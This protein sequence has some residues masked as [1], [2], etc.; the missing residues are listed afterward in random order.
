MDFSKIFL[1]D[2]CPTKVGGQAVL[3]GIM[4]K[5]EKRSAT[6]LRLPDGSI[7]L[8]TEE[9]KKPSKG[10]RIPFIRG[11]IV[12]F[13]SLVQGMKVLMYSADVLEACEAER[14]QEEGEEEDKLTAWLEEKFGEKGA[15]NIMI[16]ASVIFSLIFTVVVFII[17]P[18]WVVGLCRAFMENE[19]LLNLIEGVLRI[20]MFLLYVVIIARMPEIHRVFQYHGAEHQCI[21]CFENGEDLTP[22]NC[23][24]YY[25]LHPR[26]GTSFL[27]F[28]LVISLIL[29]SLC[30]WPDLFWRITSRLLLL[31]VISGISYELLRLAGRSDGM[32]VKVMSIPGL[33]MQ[34][35]TT[36]KPDRKELE[37]AIAAMKAAMDEKRPLGEGICDK[38]GVI[39]EERIYSDRKRKMDEK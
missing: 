9:N 4:M 3:E 34:K 32:F 5:G 19:V 2:A 27:M 28:V 12:F 36:A 30:G 15:W 1:K 24:R 25:T 35:I 11:V 39:V 21:H 31:P 16:Y 8:K 10:A 6:A 29:F 13:G 37:V 20:L 23:E 38:D 26:C 33:Y 18:T 17:G 22:E 14:G 7:H